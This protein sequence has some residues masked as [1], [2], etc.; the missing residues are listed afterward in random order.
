MFESHN[1]PDSSRGDVGAWSVP[2]PG[3]LRIVDVVPFAG[4]HREKNVLAAAWERA[5]AGLAGWS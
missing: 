3:S 5:R 4:R 1:A 2:L